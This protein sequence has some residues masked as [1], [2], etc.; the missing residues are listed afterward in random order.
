VAEEAERAKTIKYQA[1]TDRYWFVPVG[2]ETLGVWG[3]SASKFVKD[4]G[5]RIQCAT[6]ERRATSFLMQAISVAIQ[7]GNAV[8]MLGTVRQQPS[9]NEIYDLSGGA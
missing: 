9:L 6:G 7:R 3:A 4:L 5:Q 8:S 2:V 1:L